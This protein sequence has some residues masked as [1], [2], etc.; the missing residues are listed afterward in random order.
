MLIVLSLLVCVGASE[1]QKE[2]KQLQADI[3]TIQETLAEE[4]AFLRETQAKVDRLEQL[5]ND[6][7]AD[8]DEA[9][10]NIF[11]ILLFVVCFNP[12]IP[13]GLFDLSLW[14]GSLPI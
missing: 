2:I 4:D 13:S 14:S 12:L 7:I 3:K 1:L 11:L 6:A 9:S 5:I 10:K 8:R